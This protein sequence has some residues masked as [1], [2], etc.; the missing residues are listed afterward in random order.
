MN[1]VVNMGSRQ[2]HIGVNNLPK[3][4]TQRCLEQHLNLRPTDRKPKCLTRY[5]TAPPMW[6]CDQGQNAKDSA[7]TFVAS[8]L[9]YEG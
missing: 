3:V 5:T 1:I 4:V 7:W 9:D 2:R 6:R 8:A